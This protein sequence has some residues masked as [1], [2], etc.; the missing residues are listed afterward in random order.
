MGEPIANTSYTIKVKALTGSTKQ[1]VNTI[2]APDPTIKVGNSPII[3]FMLPFVASGCVFAPNNH[4]S[5][6]GV[7]VAT[8]IN[9]FNN[10]PVLRK[11]DKGVCT[12]SFISPPPANATIPCSCMIEIDDAGQSDA[13]SN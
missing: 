8:S 10:L 7:I 13:K 3:G 6:G 9:K 12:G 4:I 2:P 11:G 1:T 5:G